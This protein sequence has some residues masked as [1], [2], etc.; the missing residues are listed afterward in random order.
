M[1]KGSQEQAMRILGALSGVD[2]RLLERAGAERKVF[3]RRLI[4]SWAAVLCLFAVGA[5]C[6]GGYQL[7]QVRM[8]AIG[9]MEKSAQ[10]LVPFEI[11]QDGAEAE[12][13]GAEAVQGAQNDM[14][15]DMKNDTDVKNMAEANGQEALEGEDLEIDTFSMSV[16][17]PFRQKNLT[18]EEA[19]ALETLGE[20]IPSAI[21]RG[22]VFE[23]AY[24]N[25]DRTEGN[26]T[27][28]WRR[29]MDSIRWSVSEAEAMPAIVD[30]DNPTF[31]SADFTL[32]IVGSRMVTY[33]DSG[34]TD[35]PRGSFAVWYPDGVKISFNGRGTPEEI[36]A[37]FAS[38]GQ[39]GGAGE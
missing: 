16:C 19:R 5:A 27:V 17:P 18:E 33:A 10:S 30:A 38:L 6:W 37:M 26:V 15:N 11:A 4:G 28:T 32:E 8:G 14:V 29:G 1:R 36:Y 35:T 21:P 34:D 20:Y 12:A 22:Y 31:A 3:P 2:E 25:E 39:T 7:T 24:R 23:R 13:G 9:G